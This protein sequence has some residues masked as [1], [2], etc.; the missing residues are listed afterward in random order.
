MLIDTTIELDNT[1]IDIKYCK[2]VAPVYCKET[3]WDSLEQ[4]VP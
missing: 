4:K 2:D 1:Y 3:I